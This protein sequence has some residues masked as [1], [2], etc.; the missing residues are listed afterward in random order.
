MTDPTSDADPTADAEAGTEEQPQPFENRA[1]RR[2]KGKATAK[3]IGGTA[4]R[5]HGRSGTVQTPRQYGNR[6][7]G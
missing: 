2:S 3:H 7:S 5:A 4:S 1:A 6:R